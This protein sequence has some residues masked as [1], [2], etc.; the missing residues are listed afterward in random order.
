MLALAG[1]ITILGVL[2]G[3]MTKR[4]SPIMALILVPVVVASVA[5]GAADV[6]DYMLQGIVSIAP[7]AVMFMFAILFFG[8][9]NDAGDIACVQ[10]AICNGLAGRI[11]AV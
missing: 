8:I 1:F 6:P 4:L 11:R 10:P 7:V 5:V 3:I 2:L 9:M